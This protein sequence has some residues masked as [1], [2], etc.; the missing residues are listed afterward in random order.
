MAMDGLRQDAVAVVEEEYEDEDDGGQKTELDARPNLH[1]A[2]ACALET[3]DGR[4]RAAYDSTGH[5]G[6]RG[7]RR[8]GASVAFI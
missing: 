2:L 6:V 3:G 1:H 8:V 7:G 4:R 5:G